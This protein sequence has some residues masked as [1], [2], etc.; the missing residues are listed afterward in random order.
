MRSRETP[1]GVGAGGDRDRDRD[2][3]RGLELPLVGFYRF[4][5]IARQV[6]LGRDLDLCQFVQEL[7]RL[8]SYHIFKSTRILV[9]DSVT[10]SY[11]ATHANM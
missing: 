7:L 1:R 8:R 5:V 10:S 11:I 3:D 6:R 9:R 2:L 4:H